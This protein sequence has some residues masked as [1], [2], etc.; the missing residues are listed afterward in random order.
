[1]P[2]TV[3]TL[4]R[5]L[6]VVQQGRDIVF[7]F[8]SSD[9][10]VTPLL[11]N[12]LR[13]TWIPRHWRL[14]TERVSG[15]YAARRQL[16]PAVSR[17]TIVETAE[18]VRVR[19]GEILLDATRDP[20]HLRYSTLD[21]ETF[22][23]EL[24]AGGLSWSYW[25]YALRFH[26]A[27]GDHFYGMGQVDQLDD[28]VDLDHRGHRREVWNQHSP[29]AITILPAVYSLRG[30][31]LL[32]DNPRRATW[33]LGQS[34]SSV[35]SYTAGGGGL[36]YYVFFGPGL[37]RLLHTYLELTGHPPMPPRWAL[38][39]LQS[40][41]GYRN[42]RELEEIARTFR[43]K[44]L[45]CDALILDVYWFREMGDLAFDPLDWPD[46]PDMIARLREQGFRIMLIEEPYVTTRSSNFHDALSSGYLAR[47][48]DGAP[49]TF[50][51]WPGQC[52]L[53]D[54]SNPAACAW[55]TEKHRPLLEMGVGGWWADLNEPAKHYP[56]MRHQAGSAPMVHNLTALSIHQSVFEAVQ[57]YAPRQR[58]FILS[59]SAFAGSQRYGAALWSGDVDMTFAALRKQAAV[60]LSTGM[61]GFPLW[62]TDIGGFGFE[63]KCSPE[64]YARWFQFGAFSPL[65]RPHGDQTELREPWQFGPEIEA[66]CLKYLRLR[67]R[68]LPYIYTALHEAC[69]S[70]IPLMRALVLEFP[71]DPQVLNLSDQYLFG[72]EILVAP[73]MDEGAT[74]RS[75]YL[76]AGE[77]ID[78]WND[79]AHTGC[80]S[81]DVA[82]P[83]DTL[84][85]FVRRGAI[86]P[87]GPDVQHSSQSAGEELTLE[88]YRG[89]DRSFVLYEDD[90]ETTDYQ[91]GDCAETPIDVTAAPGFLTCRIG[92]PRGN[93]APAKSARTVLINVHCQPQVRAVVCDGGPLDPLPDA[94]TFDRLQ[95][96]WWWDRAHGILK[97]K[98]PRTLPT[99]TV[100]VSDY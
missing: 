40:R 58:T 95:S 30:Y 39:L 68:L 87:V 4:G 66:I 18:T 49:Y 99:L 22:L 54:F 28:P 53:L 32:V 12:L 83:L 52:A 15:P 29:P 94:E 100:R 75:V 3:G 17:A 98:S 7:S 64:L 23:E 74:G 36:Q 56:D 70:G 35:L 31:G 63:G 51:F 27:P 97:L 90:G 25:D 84:P 59:R 86:I 62:G 41:Y 85:L 11:P 26:L 80:Q 77:W 89:A 78:F 96:G 20:F 47:H 93:F 21:G 2:I 60:G 55:W 19:C 65:C 14:Y 24:P 42:R 16:W 71:N 44:R 9:L 73:V 38:G 34:D 50:D 67:Y 10:A 5:L 72:P 37:P 1:M 88:L 61:A 45:P 79:A 81:L 33:D 57:R 6:G 69:V 8:E 48:Y 43:D 46:A 13:H 92:E 76:P 82:A 91:N